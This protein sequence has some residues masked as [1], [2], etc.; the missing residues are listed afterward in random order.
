MTC[1]TLPVA[2]A[3]SMLALMVIATQACGGRGEVD[4]DEIRPSTKAPGRVSRTAAGDALVRLEPASQTRIGLRTQ[5]LTAQAM[6]PAVVAYGRLEEDPARSFILRAPVAGTLHLAPG[7]TWPSI[8]QH[9]ADGDLAGMIEPRLAPSERIGLADQLATARSELRAS[10]ASTAAAKAAYER[11]RILNADNKNVSDRVV[12]DASARFRAEEARLQAATDNVGLLEN[13]LR[14]AGP[15]GNQPLI[16]ERGGDVVEIMAQPG[17]SIE[18]GSPIL[19]VAR[20]DRLLARVD[21]PPGQ[22]VPASA[23]AARIYA[24]GYE[25]TPIPAERVALA[26][27]V[28]P[29]SQGES[30]LFRLKKTLFGLRP[31]VA[32][33]AR[34]TVP[35]AVRRGVV[36]PLT[37]IV[38]MGGQCYAYVQA[39]TNQ[40]VRK[41]VNVDEPVEH[42]YFTTANFSA[43]DRV[44]VQGAQ[45]LLS[46]EFKSQTTA[47]EE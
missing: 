26:A 4:E 13:S 46:E 42:G 5:T 21:V 28:D 23:T 32:V 24:V 11:A 12:E 25:N 17:E 30:F 16:A 31:G 47:E 35:G 36:I 3:A 14:A 45:I 2:I 43:G 6:Q 41:E 20:L 7:R 10:T 33:V 37:A 29:K 34:I 39:G 1:R 44:V 15:A 27:T 40:F 19:R 22:R 38:H 18:A 9:L 8:G